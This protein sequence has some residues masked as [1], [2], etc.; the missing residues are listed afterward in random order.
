[1]ANSASSVGAQFVDSAQ[2]QLDG[3]GFISVGG[4]E[5]FQGKQV[6]IFVGAILHSSV[7][8]RDN[9]AGCAGSGLWWPC[10]T[11]TTV[12]FMTAER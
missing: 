4:R 5:G 1:M 10:L 7:K 9:W 12:V 3:F 2:V 6:R 8:C 11:G